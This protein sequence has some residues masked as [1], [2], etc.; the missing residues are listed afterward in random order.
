MADVF[1]LLQGWSPNGGAVHPVDERGDYPDLAAAQEAAGTG[2]TW[3]WM[4]VRGVWRAATGREE[5]AEIMPCRRLA[6]IT[7]ETGLLA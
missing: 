2:L 7:V 3:E 4:P 1:K 5:A 6:G